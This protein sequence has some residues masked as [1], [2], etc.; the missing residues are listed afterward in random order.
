MNKK[1]LILL[2][3]CIYTFFIQQASAINK[4]EVE[5]IIHN[6]LLQH[7]EIMLEVQ[8]NLAK[9]QQTAILEERSKILQSYGSRI[10]NASEDLVLGNPHAP[11]SIIEFFDYNCGY[12]KQSNAALEALVASHKD[13]RIIVKDLPIL[14]E[15]SLQAHMI[16]RAF[17][18]L[19]PKKQQEFWHNMMNLNERAT[20]KS[21]LELAAKL[22]AD[23]KLLEQKLGDE[24]ENKNLQA[25]LLEN[26]QLAMALK[27]QGTPCYIVNNKIY[28]GVGNLELLANEASKN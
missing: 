10:Y 1:L 13:L 8:E 21:T 7:P 16:A 4:Q 23:T 3:C 17:R 5:N 19:Y 22:G 28:D 14:G 24:K 26:V 6:Y 18:S 9:K 25:Y 27:I 20:K 11:H 2:I 12:C 15:D